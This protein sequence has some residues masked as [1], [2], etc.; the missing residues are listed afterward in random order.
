MVSTKTTKIEPPRNIMISQYLNIY[1]Y[2]IACYL[3]P[4]NNDKIIF[5]EIKFNIIFSYRV[6]IPYTILYT[7]L[8]VHYFLKCRVLMF[9][10]CID[11]SCTEFK[12]EEKKTGN[13]TQC[14]HF[15]VKCAVFMHFDIRIF[16]NILRECC[17]N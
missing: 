16:L 5:I 15:F 4:I 6:N 8:Y 2:I 14:I 10:L 9:V 3:L 13:L 12:L 17:M 7:F 1:R 11:I